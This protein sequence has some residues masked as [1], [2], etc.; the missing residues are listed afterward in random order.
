MSGNVQWAKNK[1]NLCIKTEPAT[2]EADATVYVWFLS[3]IYVYCTVVC[4]DGGE[5]GGSYQCL[6]ISAQTDN[7]FQI[8]ME[9]NHN[10]T[11]R[12][13]K[14]MQIFFLLSFA[15]FL[16]F[17]RLWVILMLLLLFSVLA[18]ILTNFD[19]I[20]VIRSCLMIWT[21]QLWY[22]QCCGAVPFLTGSGFFPPAS[23]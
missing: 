19:K 4:L 18:R 16:H 22:A 6:V 20:F 10:A 7:S 17:F 12:Y 21:L 5:G 2:V 9:N 14:Q 8:Y 11:T 1:L 3:H 15:F 23:I 13:N